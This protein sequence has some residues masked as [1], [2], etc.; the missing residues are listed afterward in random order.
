M[1][2]KFIFFLK[3]W[4][5]IKLDKNEISFIKFLKEQNIY[6]KKNKTLIINSLFSYF[7]LVFVFLLSIEKKYK[8]YHFIFC[9]PHMY[10]YRY[11]LNDNIL[12][13][14]IK[15]YKSLFFFYLMNY[16]FL[17]FFKFIS[18]E[19]FD[20]VNKN[21]FKEIYLLKI[22]KKIV[23]NINCK[24]DLQKI[25]FRGI[26]IGDNVY[27]TYL[28]FKNIGTVNLKDP[29]LIELIS[30]SIFIIIKLE[31]I[32]RNRKMSLYLTLDKC[33]INH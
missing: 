25:R 23:S 7:N 5:V 14:I 22:S 27:D 28:R 18:K 15:Y 13:F 17:N 20:L 29:F 1:I 31:N 19:S 3:E 32:I 33:Y 16:N 30:K 12:I 26:L 4:R 2:K 24:T 10:F 6:P 21:I 8:S 11:D 9:K